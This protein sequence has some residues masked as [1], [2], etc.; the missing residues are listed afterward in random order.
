MANFLAPCEKLTGKGFPVQVLKPW[1]RIGQPAEHQHEGRVG[2][3]AAGWALG[4]QQGQEG[5]SEAKG[6]RCKGSGDTPSQGLQMQVALR[7]GT[8]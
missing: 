8:P 3:Q 5:A 6:G 1:S 4:C 2:D 7:V